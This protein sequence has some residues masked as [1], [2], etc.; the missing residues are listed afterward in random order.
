MFSRKSEIEPQQS[1]ARPVQH[2]NHPGG[3]SL[4]GSDVTI[5]GD[6]VATA[7]LRVDGRIEGDIS[8]ASL[9]Q[10][11]SSAI[12]GTITTETARLAGAI[13]GSIS[14]RELT[15]LRTARIEGDVQ[16]DALTIEQGAQVEGRFSHRA[17]ARPATE[18][19]SPP[20]TPGDDE[21]RLTLAS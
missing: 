9:V 13:S 3:S 15:V 19:A 21:P 12:V 1:V 8:C 18:A 11:E 4:I 14:A 7:D 6:V 5:K 10:G 17:P 16:Y 20:K 2:D